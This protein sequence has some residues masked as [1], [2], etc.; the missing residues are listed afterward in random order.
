[1]QIFFVSLLFLS[2]SSR[3]TVSSTNLC[4]VFCLIRYL[5]L[6][7]HRWFASSYL[8]GSLI[9]VYKE[10]A[11]KERSFWRRWYHLCDKNSCYNIA[12]TRVLRY[13]TPSDVISGC[14]FFA[15]MIKRKGGGW[16][17][18]GRKTNLSS[19]VIPPL[20]FFFSFKLMQLLFWK[21][22]HF[23]RG[24]FFAYFFALYFEFE[25][26]NLLRGGGEG[27]GALINKAGKKFSKQF[28]Q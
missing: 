12:V 23:F 24:L 3:V 15:V 17:Y 18:A 21:Y 9:V 26:L 16:E 4:R 13:D 6:S 8:G 7:L 2:Q 19:L 1:M 5:D 10:I 20:N 25:L 28:S 11:R 14:F 22:C 27:E